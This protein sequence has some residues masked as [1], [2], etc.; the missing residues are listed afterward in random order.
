MSSQLADVWWPG[1]CQWHRWLCIST[2]L[3]SS[4]RAVLQR[5]LLRQVPMNY[6]QV[7]AFA[8]CSCGLL[9]FMNLVS[10]FSC[11]LAKSCTEPVPGLHKYP[12]C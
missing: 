10:E 9:T 6:V 12:C 11:K 5:V 3:A 7:F 1:L 4:E 8:C 2:G